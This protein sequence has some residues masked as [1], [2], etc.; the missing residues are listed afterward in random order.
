M[1]LI[2]LKC[3]SCSANLEVIENGMSTCGNCQTIHYLMSEGNV[4]RITSKVDGVVE[5]EIPTVIAVGL[6]LRELG[7]HISVRKWGSNHYDNGPIKS[8]ASS[9][10]LAETRHY[11]QQ[12]RVHKGFLGLS[13]SL[14]EKE[15]PYLNR[16]AVL[17]F[18]ETGSLKIKVPLSEVAKAKALGEKIE[19]ALNLPTRVAVSST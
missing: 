19:N 2:A 1:E 3:M 10:Y 17:S 8:N 6:Y 11:T 7:K 15:V 16:W 14:E 12:V 5:V 4:I 13:S 18:E 9:L